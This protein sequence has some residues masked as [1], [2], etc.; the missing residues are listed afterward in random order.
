MFVRSWRLGVKIAY[1]L[2]INVFE[3]TET[4]WVVSLHSA[5]ALL[6]CYIGQVLNENVGRRRTLTGSAVPAVLGAVC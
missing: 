5:G 1:F 6:G 4:S 3:Q 2:D